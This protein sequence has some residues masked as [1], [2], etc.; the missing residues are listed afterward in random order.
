MNNIN[1][2]QRDP[3]WA[4]IPVG[5]GIQTIS[6]IGCTISVIGDILGITPDVVNERLKAVNGFA[7][8]NLVIWA[9]I[10][11]AFPGIAVRRVWSYNNDDVK[12]NVP[13]VIV[14]VPAAP[15]GGRG[16]HWVNYIGNHQLKDPWT[17]S[18]RATSDF[19]NP[20]GY[21]VIT[22]TWNQSVG[23]DVKINEIKSVIDQPGTPHDKLTKIDAILKQ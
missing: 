3:R 23:D 2:N 9:K 22:G 15:I 20:T 10:A 1:N 21:A 6:Q 16:S 12:A 7:N 5:F 14:E 18:I 4:N 17:G 13:N 11:E 8:G 19:P